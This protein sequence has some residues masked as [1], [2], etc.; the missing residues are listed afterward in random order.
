MLSANRTFWWGKIESFCINW[1]VLTAT[2][3]SKSSPSNEMLKEKLMA[4]AEND[5]EKKNKKIRL[6]G[7]QL[8]TASRYT[9]TCKMDWRY[10][11][12]TWCGATEYL[13]EWLNCSF[14]PFHPLK[15]MNHYSPRWA[16]VWEIYQIV[17][18]WEKEPSRGKTSPLGMQGISSAGSLRCRTELAAILFTTKHCTKGYKF[19]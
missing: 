2:V 18:F 7:P 13:T 3:I 10:P 12:S 4:Q 1:S 17:L 15:N 5:K 14:P 8:C 19:A 9:Q 16:T 11:I 6:Q